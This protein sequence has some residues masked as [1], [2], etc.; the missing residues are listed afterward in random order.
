MLLGDPL[1]VYVQVPSVRGQDCGRRAGTFRG[2]G[3]GMSPQERTYIPEDQRHANKNSQAAFCYSE[4]IPA[5][6]GKDDAQRKSVSSAP[7]GKHRPVCRAQPP[8][9]RGFPPPS[10]SLLSPS[11]YSTPAGRTKHSSAICYKSH[12]HSKDEEHFGRRAHGWG[13]LLS[14]RTS[15][16][17]LQ[18]LGHISG[19]PPGCFGASLYRTPHQHSLPLSCRHFRT[20][21][22]FGFRCSSSS[23]G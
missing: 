6:T 5:P 18:E 11:Y 15:L 1:N 3:L 14:L 21:S 13:V 10:T 19:S 4:A 7:E 22:C 20:W 12:S 8:L 9:A 17:P 23:P 16:Y 2:T